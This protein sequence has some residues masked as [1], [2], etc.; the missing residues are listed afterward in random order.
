MK[1]TLIHPPWYV[2]I[3]GS[4]QQ[5]NLSQCLGLGYIASYLK[6]K[7]HQVAFIDALAQGRDQKVKLRQGKQLL[8]RKGLSYE[9]IIQQIRPDTELV[10]I[11][12]PFSNVARI[13]KELASAIKKSYP[14]I[15]IIT[16]GVHASTFPKD[17]LTADIDYALRGEGELAMAELASG[18]DPKTIKGIFY[19]ENNIVAEKGV[20]D[21]VTDLDK[22]PLPFRPE[23]L[24]NQ[25][26][27]F[28]PRGQ[29]EKRSYSIITSRGCPHDCW[30]CSVHPV[31]GYKWRSRSAE[32]VI[33]EIK[34]VI[35]KYDVNHI[36]FED[37]NLTL[38]TARAEKI[39]NGILALDKKITWAV[40][41]G[42][43]IDTLSWP[44]IRKMKES[45]CTQMALALE[46]G[47]EKVL[48]LMNKKLKLEKAE[49]V[50][51][52]CKEVGISTIAFL[53]VGY[54]G[55]TRKTFR[56][57][58]RFI[59]K[60]KNLGL[61]RVGPMIVNAYP[62]T[63]LYDQAKEKG[64]LAKDIDQHIFVDTKYV[65]ITT[66]DFNQ[67]RVFYWEAQLQGIFHPIKWQ[68]KKLIWP[69]YYLIYK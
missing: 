43:R 39:F 51:R 19:R 5:D 6:A 40:N 18:Q 34:E 65:S 11:S 25:Y 24:I 48:K 53:L 36:E 22:L 41:N 26:L 56:E 33:A 45:G 15:S 7:G 42:L 27:S 46:S 21:K 16:G 3:R 20:A 63:K 49:E 28:S 62:G 58:L 69:I 57:T 67:N 66:P 60:M 35:E 44:L 10:G 59:K 52:I 38:D 17:M 61:N 1:I 32:N 68:I 12:V 47:N 4:Y 55:E 2:S 54:P 31:C 64:Y 37:D 50:I 8:Y 23:N 13:V 30:F 14:N 29:T 9:E